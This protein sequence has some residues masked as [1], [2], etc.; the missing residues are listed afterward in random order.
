MISKLKTGQ[1]NGT[2][3]PRLETGHLI[4]TMMLELETGIV[5]SAMVSYPRKQLILNPSKLK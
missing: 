3:M 4:G 1:N 2:L 5:T